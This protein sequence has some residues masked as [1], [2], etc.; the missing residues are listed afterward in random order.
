MTSLQDIVAAVASAHDRS[1]ALPYNK[2]PGHSR[3]DGDRYEECMLALVFLRCLRSQLIFQL[4]ANNNDADKFDDVVLAWRPEEDAEE[5]TLLVQL[6]HKTSSRQLTLESDVWLSKDTDFSISKYCTSYGKICKSLVMDRVTLVFLTNARLGESSLSLFERQLVDTVK[7]LELLKAGGDLYKLDSNNEQVRKAVRGNMSFVQH[8]YLLCHQKNSVEIVEDICSELDKLLGAGNL[9]ESICESLCKSLREWMNEASVCLTSSWSKWQ[10]IVGDYIRKEV[11]RC[12]VVTTRLEYCCVGDIRRYVESCNPAWVIIDEDSE[13]SSEILHELVAQIQTERRLIIV[14]SRETNGYVDTFESADISDDS[15]NKWMDTDIRLNGDHYECHLRDLVASVSALKSVLDDEPALLLA[16]A[17]LSQP[18]RMGP[19]LEPL[20]AYYIPRKLVD[21]RIELADFV[22]SLGSRDV[23]ITNSACYE[24]LESKIGRHSLTS[25]EEVVRWI[26]NKSE[27]D[28]PLFVLTDNLES[29]PENIRRLA[30]FNFYILLIS[31]DSCK[32]RHFSGRSCRVLE[33]PRE[34]RK[35]QLEVLDTASN[36]VIVE[37]KPGVGKSK[38]LSH[39][40]KQIKER[41]PA[42]WLLRVN[43]LEF[44]TVLDHSCSGITGVRDILFQTVFNDD[45]LGRLEYALL[46]HSLSH[47]PRVVCLVDGFDE[48]CPDYVTECLEILNLLAPRQGKLLVTTRPAPLKLLE[49]RLG[50]PAYSLDPFTDSELEDFFRHHPSRGRIPPINGLNSNLRDLL[51]IPLFAEMFV[52]VSQEVPDTYDIVTLYEAFF[53]NE[54]RRYYKEKW[55]HNLSTPGRKIELEKAQKKH[56]KHLMLL[57]TSILLRSTDIPARPLVDMDYFVKAGIVYKFANRKPTFLHRTFAEHFLAK[58]CF[59][60]EGERRRAAV[61]REA[62]LDRTLE[63]FLEAFNRRAARDRP[64]LEALLG[65]DKDRLQAVMAEGADPRQRDA[66][67][68]NALHLAAALDEQR[69]LPLLRR[70]CRYV[71]EGML[72]VEDG[73]LGWT[74]MRYAA[75]GRHWIAVKK[76]LEAGDD[77]RH[78]GDFHAGLHDPAQLCDV[79]RRSGYQALYQH[80]IKQPVE[81]AAQQMEFAVSLISANMPREALSH[82]AGKAWEKG[83][84]LVWHL[85]LRAYGTTVEEEMGRWMKLAKLLA[86]D[87]RSYRLRNHLIGG[88]LQDVPAERNC[89]NWSPN[90]PSS[91][92]EV[93]DEN[94]AA[95]AEAEMV[96][97]VVRSPAVASRSGWTQGQHNGDTYSLLHYAAAFGSSR[98]LRTLINSGADLD[99]RDVFGCTAV[100]Y[101]AAAGNTQCLS[102]LAEAGADVWAKCYGGWTALHLAARRGHEDTVRLLLGFLRNQSHALLVAHVNGKNSDGVSP[103]TCALKSRS[104]TCVRLLLDAG[105]VRE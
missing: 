64:L 59:V 86:K 79:F 39:V 14:S 77:L 32:I 65:G 76:L 87:V 45:Q 8:F 31:E 62:Y 97:A 21:P 9:C 94:D 81:K 102:L 20:P 48:V 100:H 99:E 7:G 105:A 13:E 18:L 67:G 90:S 61:Y 50:V 49:A 75:E 73:L 24:L 58:W 15:W 43:L 53:K 84:T 34:Q 63:F 56:E 27:F 6:K 83:H 54:F 19:E 4:S 95:R 3:G 88:Q 47:S 93:P 41:D 38:M 92:P 72:S 42:C 60:R 52:N 33:Y 46:R 55:G 96:P 44:D 78:L 89:S 5:H 12:R 66:C 16:L 36:I 25:F 11:T 70:L 17:Q 2:K 57:A 10:A 91:S 69:S 82:I 40:A 35:E 37:G 85:L 22:S 104:A 30:V 29:I 71:G 28:W 103:L 80:I 74:P 51:K 101:A 23:C 26:L 68:R 98:K 1:A